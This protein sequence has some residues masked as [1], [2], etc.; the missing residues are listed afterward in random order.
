MK[1]F[2]NISLTALA[3]MTLLTSAVG[4]ASAN[5]DKSHVIPSN[6]YVYPQ[7]DLV[8]DKSNLKAF[9]T[10]GLHLYP[11]QII[12]IKIDHHLIYPASGIHKSL[13]QITFGKRTMYRARENGSSG[14]L[15]IESGVVIPFYGLWALS[16]MG[17]EHVLDAV[18]D[19]SAPDD[20]QKLS[21]K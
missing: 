7:P 17:R 6:Q 3:T 8:I 19:Q 15:S 10:E 21:Q 12:E 5:E 1:T 20:N 13:D 18:V 16:A 14:K 11:G 9:E 2:T 4:I